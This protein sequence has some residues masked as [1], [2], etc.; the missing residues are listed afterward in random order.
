M[1]RELG[2]EVEN[3]VKIHFLKI[4]RGKLVLFEL[5]FFFFSVAQCWALCVHT[6]RP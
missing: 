3:W 2:T 4:K 1:A 5:I 6:V